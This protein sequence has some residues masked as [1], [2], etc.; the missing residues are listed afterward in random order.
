[1]DTLTVADQ[2]KLVFWN[3][4]GLFNKHHDLEFFAKHHELDTIL[5]NETH[6]RASYRV[7]IPSYTVHKKLGQVRKLKT[8]Y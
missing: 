1:M 3:A 4:N 5:L 6:L 8:H 2:L 7:K